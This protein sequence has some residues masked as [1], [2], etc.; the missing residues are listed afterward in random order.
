MKPRLV[1]PVDLFN[2]PSEVYIAT[3]A[4]GSRWATDRIVLVRLDHPVP[5]VLDGLAGLE[6]GVWEIR[7]LKPPRRL[8]DV[9][10]PLDRVFDRDWSAAG[11]VYP[12]PGLLLRGH[13]EQIHYRPLVTSPG[14]DEVAAVV[15]NRLW[16][17]L[18]DS[19]PH[20]SE[21]DV[22][23]NQTGK[24]PGSGIVRITVH[25][26]R[27]EP[28]AMGYLMTI[29]MGGPVTLPVIPEGVLA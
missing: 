8:D 18:I 10:A 20:R 25:P 9:T 14:G 15:D 4:D 19:S 2:D 28:Y 29:A 16:K 26:V 6:D 27:D 13:S 1:R 11:A 23:F 12:W 7:A 5:T 21:P 22:E 24:H 3:A 17:A